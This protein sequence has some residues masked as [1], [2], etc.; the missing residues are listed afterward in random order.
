M[1]YS[2]GQFYPVVSVPLRLY[3]S[4]YRASERNTYQSGY[5]NQSGNYKIINIKWTNANGDY[6]ETKPT[7]GGIA[8]YAIND[9]T[10]RY[11]IGWIRDDDNIQAVNFYDV[12]ASFTTNDEAYSIGLRGSK[13]VS[14]RYTAM[15]GSHK[16]HE[17]NGTLSQ[18]REK[19][20]HTLTET[21]KNRIFEALGNKSSGTMNIT[22][23]SNYNGKEIKTETTSIYVTIPMS[24][25]PEI[26]TDPIIEEIDL[27]NEKAYQKISSF[28]VTASPDDVVLKDRATLTTIEVQIG[29]LFKTGSESSVTLNS[30]VI[31]QSGNVQIK[32]TYTDSL[33]RSASK[34]VTKFVEPYVPI[35]IDSLTVNRTPTGFHLKASGH[36]P[37][38]FGDELDYHIRIK[39]RSVNEWSTVV[40]D[41]SEQLGGYF[42][43]DLHQQ[44]ADQVAQDI[45]FLITDGA[46]V[47]ARGIAVLGT[48]A[49]PLA[50][51]KRGIGVGK[52]VDNADG[53]ADLQ[54]GPNGIDS[55]GP[56]KIDGKDILEMFKA[57][58]NSNLIKINELKGT[59]DLNNCIATGD[60]RG[61]L[62]EVANSPIDK[63]DIYLTVKNID[64]VVY[65]LLFA[66]S[67]I[68]YR[69]KTTTGWSS[70]INV[71]ND[72]PETGYKNYGYY[73]KY[74]DGRIV[75]T[76]TIVKTFSNG[77]DIASLFEDFYFP[78]VMPNNTVVTMSLDTTGLNATETQENQDA[79]SLLT[80]H[81]K[82]YAWKIV[83]NM[84]AKYTINPRGKFQVAGTNSYK[85]TIKLRAEGNWK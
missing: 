17:Y 18:E 57:P 53:Q 84:Y 35:N 76:R 7:T 62:T 36:Y 56:I 67:T 23:V 48:E 34:T 80:L 46:G 29:H 50:L 79:Y 60:Y 51:G 82:E 26:V 65:Q 63:G 54:V 10:N 43:I 68:Y 55:E 24:N 8:L 66:S 28:E 25:I 58:D 31:N 15:I 14:Y 39:P 13:S 21:A 12:P 72:A 3:Y 37:E 2:V 22:V 77:T 70:W 41:V 47:T 61:T 33:N 52:M 59:A 16:I 19:F 40:T 20:T 69:M 73:Y 11:A 27:V 75:A 49:V 83:P 81:Q 71:A 9:I 78:I 42:T 5:V 64:A 4:S 1:A 6:F 32:V 85:M 74:S 45:E 38:Q 30:G 44:F